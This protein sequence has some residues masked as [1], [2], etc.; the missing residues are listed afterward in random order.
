MKCRE[1]VKALQQ[2][3]YKALAQM[4]LEDTRCRTVSIC[5]VPKAICTGS[6]AITIRQHIVI[7]NIK[8]TSIFRV[9]LAGPVNPL[10]GTVHQFWSLGLCP[11]LTA[12]T[13]KCVCIESPVWGDYIRVA[14]VQ[15]M[16]HE[17]RMNHL[18]HSGNSGAG[19]HS[20]A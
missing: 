17:L 5:S 15:L 12:N 18:E 16:V 2:Y 1:Y 7:G 19:S 4:R 9:D 11:L 3:A 10:T 6:N 8:Y 20:P 14:S 13:C